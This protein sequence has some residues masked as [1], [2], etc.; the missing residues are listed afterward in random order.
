MR[1][2]QQ[3][4]PMTLDDVVGQPAIVRRLKRLVAAPYPCCLLFEGRGGVGKSAHA[5]GTVM[6]RTFPKR[7][8]DLPPNDHA[9][10]VDAVVHDLQSQGW[11][12]EEDR[13][14]AQRSR[15]RLLPKAVQYGILA[16]DEK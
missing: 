5:V 14:R 12:S 2:S 15:Q 8:F 11:A 10:V 13:K 6:K 9:A 16:E 1:L 4:Q 3:F 7:V